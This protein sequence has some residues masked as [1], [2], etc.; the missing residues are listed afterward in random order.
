[1]TAKVYLV[2]ELGTPE[3]SYARIMWAFSSWQSAEK[4]LNGFLSENPE[5]DRTRFCISTLEVSD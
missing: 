1:M 3:A 5:A 4:F 2:K